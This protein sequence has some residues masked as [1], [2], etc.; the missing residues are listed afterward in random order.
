ML[1]YLGEEKDYLND[2][3]SAAAA[4]ID[5]E[6]DAI[7]DDADAQADSIQK[8]ID[9]LE[10][11]KKPLQDEL[12]ALEDKAKHE[13]LIYNLQK[14]QADLAKAQ[15]DLAR[16]ESQRS[17]LLYTK[18]KGM[19][20]TADEIEIRNAQDNV[21]D[22]IKDVDDAKLEIEKQA[23]QDQIALIDD[24]ISKYN[25][26]IDQ[27]N[28]ATDDQIDALERTKNKWQEAIDLQEYAKNVSLFTNEFGTDA[29]NKLLT[30]NDDDLLAQWKNNYVNTLAAIDMESQGYIG[31][32][33]QQ[34]ASL[35][36]VDLSSLQAQFGNVKDSVGEVTDALGDTISALVGGGSKEDAGEGKS[37][38]GTQGIT[39]GSQSKSPS[40]GSGGSLQDAIQSETETAMDAFDQHTDKLTNE[41]IPAIQS[42][43]E[44]MN[45]FNEAADMDIE[46]TVTITY[47][48]VGSPSLGGAANAEGTAHVEGTAK[49]SGDWGVQQGG[50]SL[51]GETGRELIVRKGRFFTVGDNG[52]E[53][54][55]LQKGDIIFNH[56]QTEKLLKD[57]KISSRGRALANGTMVEPDGTI[58]ARSGD[59]IPINSPAFQNLDP[60][61]LNIDPEQFQIY[62]KIGEISQSLDLGVMKVQGINQMMSDMVSKTVNNNVVTNNNNQPHISIGDINV[63]CPGVTS[64]EVVKE[65]GKAL[66]NQFSGLAL[67]AYQQSKITR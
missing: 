65:V 33:A 18:D 60:K 9:L 53:F 52:A 14:A 62:K 38:E 11:K 28:K 55:D 41:V 64:Q 22:K 3:A 31:D 47:N 40:S 57:G 34:M 51:V 7:Q 15:Y 13:E 59:L 63:T 29:I 8:Q 26:L 5:R 36:D 16:A 61:T 49:V 17:K 45:A 30:G 20:Y 39:S 23:L 10:A 43:T 54:I 42:A 67:K 66:E 19:I 4:I 48:V 6:I 50:K 46:K 56:T 37:E 44:E 21:D 24:E 58:H 2:V 32:M 27:I 35:Y 1:E 12:D 25:D